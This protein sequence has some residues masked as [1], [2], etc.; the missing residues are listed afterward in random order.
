MISTRSRSTSNHCNLQVAL[1]LGRLSLSRCG[2]VAIGATSKR[3]STRVGSLSGSCNSCFANARIASHPQSIS[4]TK[5]KSERPRGQK[6]L[7]H[8]V[9]RTASF[10]AQ[11]GPRTIREEVV[12]KQKAA[13]GAVDTVDRKALQR[14]VLHPAS[15][16][17]Q[18]GH[19]KLATSMTADE[20]DANVKAGL[21]CA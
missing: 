14:R 3:P 10:K 20:V 11:E 5:R 6:N 9:L 7:L 12:H 19:S 8:Y 4:E 16:N 1:S 17:K 18:I 2:I 15:P 21:D 13:N